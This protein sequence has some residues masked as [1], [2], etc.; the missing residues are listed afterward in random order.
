MDERIQKLSRLLVGYS[1]DIRK[2]D[3]CLIEYTGTAAVPLIRQL[4]RD[5]YAA[6]GLP[7]VN[8]REDTVTREILLDATEEQFGLMN[9]NQLAFMEQMQAYIAVRAG[10]NNAEFSDVPPDQMSLYRR[11]LS[12]VLDYR[13]NHT[14]WCVMRY[15]NHAMAQQAGMSLEAFEDF[16]YTVCTMDYARMDVAMDALVS[17]LEQTDSVR[18]VGPGTD[19]SFRTAGMQAIKCAG[20]MNIPDGEVFT[21]PIRDSVNGHITYNTRSLEQGFTFE[22]VYFEV[23]NGKIVRATA[24][25][26]PRINKVLDTDE[27]ARYFGEF[28]IGVNPYILTPMK[29]TLFDEKISGSFHLTPGRCYD[30]ADNGNYSALHWDLVMIQRKDWGGG[31]MYFDGELIRKDGLF[32]PDDLLD[33]NPDR[34]K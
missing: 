13:V 19:I 23:E 11:A 16:Y 3:R 14:K 34:L 17:R 29:D 32:V 20:R 7:F 12:P 4:V 21:A 9:D 30:E 18:L 5:V 6:G 10:D 31:E 33:L 28:A 22:N 24:N 26:T 8:A 15:P 25:D 1:V 2:G 27:G